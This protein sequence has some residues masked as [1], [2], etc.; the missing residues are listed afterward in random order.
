ESLTYPFVIMFAV[1]FAFVGVL[2][3]LVVTG[4]PMSIM[5]MVGAVMTIGIVVNNGIV[6]VDYANLNRERGMGI[7]RAVVDSGHSR[8]RPV[9]MTTLTTVLGMLP[10]ALGRGEGSEVWRGMGMTVAWGLSVSTLVTLVFV[11]VLY[12]IFAAFGLTRSKKKRVKAIAEK[13]E[14]K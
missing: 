8:L 13:T 3:G 10:L 14:S 1:P 4:T 11:P 5:A 9:L 6:L 2:I 12:T 7:I